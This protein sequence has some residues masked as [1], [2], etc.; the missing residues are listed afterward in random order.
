MGETF[1]E[2]T[3]KTISAIKKNKFE[4]QVDVKDDGKTYLIPSMIFEAL[5]EKVEE[6]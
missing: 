6:G 2:F 4:Y 5:F 1:Y 3:G